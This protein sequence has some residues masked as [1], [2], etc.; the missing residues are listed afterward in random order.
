MSPSDHASISWHRVDRPGHEIARLERTSYGWLLAGIVK[1]VDDGYDC[2]VEYSVAC[3]SAW[4]TRRVSVSGDVH[5][6][7]VALELAQ[8]ADGWWLVDGVARPELHGCIDVDLAF[9]PCTNT[10]PIRR[11]KLGV[12]ERAGVR[13][14]WVRFPSLDV[15]VLEQ[16]YTRTAE[17]TF[18]YESKGG[19]FRRTLTVDANGLVTDYPDFWRARV[20]NGRS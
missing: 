14:A 8:S 2:H 16:A 1:L 5:G 13:A 9:T 20:Q 11:L 6:T 17:R 15:E 3:N 7:P 12:G 4:R 10:L 18:L 19:A